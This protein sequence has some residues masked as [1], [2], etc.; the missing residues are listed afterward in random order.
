MRHL[1]SLWFA[2][3]RT[4]TKENGVQSVDIE[5]NFSVSKTRPAIILQLIHWEDS[6][7]RFSFRL[8]TLVYGS[9]VISTLI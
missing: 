8:D 1:F 7:L 2:V 4:H 3:N 6:M 5:I 9:M